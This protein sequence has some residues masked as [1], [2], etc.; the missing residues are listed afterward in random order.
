MLAG[1]GEIK[2]RMEQLR[3]SRDGYNRQLERL[4]L[5]PERAERLRREV[6]ELA[7]E[8]STLEKILQLL[9]VEP[10]SGKIEQIVRE[11]LVVVRERLAG[12][13]EL[14]GLSP[15]ERDLRS[16]EARGLLAALGEDLLS[17]LTRDLG[18]RTS[19]QDPEAIHRAEAQMLIETLET[20]ADRDTRAGAA[21]DLGRLQ[22]IRAIPALASALD[23]DPVVAEMALL[24]LGKFTDEQ[25]EDAALDAS[26]IAVVRRSRKGAT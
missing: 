8:I 26:V 25:L 13:P 24:S 17:E 9:R 16:G 21:Y 6:V 22:V 15:E 1:P 14:D 4:D 11:R 2:N 19:R 3:L 18:P 7:L 10:D 20:N 12:S 5:T 23:D